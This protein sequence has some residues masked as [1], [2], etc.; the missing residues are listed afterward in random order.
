VFD[1]YVHSNT[2]HV[3]FYERYMRGE[4]LQ[5]NWVKPTDFE[6]GPLD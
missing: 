2:A 3:G 5:A 4:K 6:K 1:K